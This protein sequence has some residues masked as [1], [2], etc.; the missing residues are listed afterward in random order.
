MGL[1]QSIVQT[2]PTLHLPFCPHRQ[3][4]DF[5]CE[6]PSLIRLSCGDT[7]YNEIQLAVSSVIFVVVPLSLI[8]VS[9]SATAQ[10]V[11]R[12]NS[13][14]AWKRP[15]GTCSSHLMVVTI[16][17]SSVIAVYLQPKNPY[18]QKRGKFFGLFYA[19]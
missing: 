17:Y 9:Y 12:I 7:T 6:V 19:V 18:A 5:L 4:D 15:L 11:L 2:P 10:A 16:F 1:A 13:A 14:H 8:L 3:I